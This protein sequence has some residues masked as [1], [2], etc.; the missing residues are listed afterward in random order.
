LL[1]IHKILM[2]ILL[3]AA[4]GATATGAA[5]RPAQAAPAETGPVQVILTL[6][7]QASLA[8]LAPQGGS[9]RA[10]RQQAVLH[11]LQDKAAHSQAPVLRR[12]RQMQAGGGVTRVRP[13]WITNAVAVSG[14]PQAVAELARLPEVAQVSED[15]PLKLADSII[16]S[17]AAVSTGVQRVRAVPVWLAGYTGEGVVVAN[18]DSGVSLNNPDLAARWRG[19][20]HSWLDLHAE[21]PQPVDLAG[22]HTGHGTNTMSIM[23]G[24]DT[25][26]APG[27][28]WIAVKLFSDAG[29]A[30]LSDALLGFQWVLD[31]DGDPATGDGAQV[32]NNSWTFNSTGCPEDIPALHQALQAMLAADVLPIFSAGNYGFDRPA[33][34]TSPG[35]YPEAFAVGSIDFDNQLSYFSSQGPTSCR[36]DGRFPDLVAPG[37]DVAVQDPYGGL[38]TNRG[39]SFSAPYVAG[40]LALLLEAFPD[41]TAAE[42][43]QI[44][45]DSA[46]DLGPAGFDTL[47]GAGRLDVFTAYRQLGGVGPHQYILIQIYK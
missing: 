6:R 25:G 45:L 3:V 28:Q 11:A 35:N 20:S 14:S 22:S 32:V 17:T 19:G 12:L 46:Y 18:L 7:D 26:V 40:A 39:T 23:V 33:T 24:T 10:G 9:D 38:T 4:L 44:L 27:A 31:P 42:Q 1:P 29:S 36:P 21:H 15:H 30:T 5:G 41:L 13:L 2:T 16:T 37:E 34:D 43:R 47:F 8:D